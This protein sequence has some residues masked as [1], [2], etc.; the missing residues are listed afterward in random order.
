MPKVVETKGARKFLF[1]FLAVLAVVFAALSLGAGLL[2][3]ADEG[4]SLGVIIA[5]LLGL[6]FIVAAFILFRLAGVKIRIW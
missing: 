6:V 2:M 3:G 4:W 5:R 1:L